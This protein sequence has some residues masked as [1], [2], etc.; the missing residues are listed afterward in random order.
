[1]AQSLFLSVSEE[2][3]VTEK[4]KWKLKR[5]TWKSYNRALHEAW[6]YVKAPAVNKLGFQ[7]HLNSDPH[8]LERQN[9]SENPSKKWKRLYCVARPDYTFEAYDT[10]ESYSSAAKPKYSLRPSG[11]CILHDADQWKHLW[12][13]RTA[14]L[15]QLNE[16]PK[17]QSSKEKNSSPAD[18][19]ICLSHP[20]KEPLFIGVETPADKEVWNLILCDFIRRT[21]DLNTVDDISKHALGA[22]I[23]R[24][25][26]LHQWR[27]PD[28]VSAGDELD[29]IYHVVTERLLGELGSIARRNPKLKNE[30]FLEKQKGKVQKSL[31]IVSKNLIGTA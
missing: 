8:W 9:K 17:I 1:M 25:R 29:V 6:C 7:I 27:D 21:A 31:K 24:T 14:I 28:L 4:V 23:E 13:R 18:Y 12:T 2:D 5:R 30:K 20:I 10:K 22:A 11:Y 16:T 19:T 26:K 3:D 15:L